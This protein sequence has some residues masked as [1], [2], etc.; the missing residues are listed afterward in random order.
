[1]V[2]LNPAWYDLTWLGSLAVARI[3]GEERMLVNE[4]EG[5]AEYK[6]KVAYRLIPFIW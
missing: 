1:M 3:I 6:K 2:A 4:L 5:Y